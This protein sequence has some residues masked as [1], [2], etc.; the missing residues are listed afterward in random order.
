VQAAGPPVRAAAQRAAGARVSP[1]AS[2]CAVGNALHARPYTADSSIG[3]SSIGDSS[4]GDSSIG[5]SSTADHR[6]VSHPLA[7][8]QLSPHI[9]STTLSLL[10]VR[11][12]ATRAH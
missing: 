9:H 7:T 3:D 4:I 1:P 8:R 12:A 11:L 10:R 5:D 2:F 6:L